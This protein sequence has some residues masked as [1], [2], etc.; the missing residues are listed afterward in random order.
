MM[1]LEWDGVGLG[2]ITTFNLRGLVRKPDENSHMRIIRLTL[3]DT[4]FLVPPQ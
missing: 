1:N 2:L 4:R 3:I